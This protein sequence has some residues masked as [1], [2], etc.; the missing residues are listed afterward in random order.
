MT[1]NIAAQA[2]Q[3]AAQGQQQLQDY[4]NKAST[5]QSQF[6]DFNNQATA[7][8]QKVSNYTDYMQGEGSAANVYH[9]EQDKQLG[10]LGY[11]PEEMTAA[12]ANLNQATGALSAYSDFANT[13]A[14]KWG[15]NAGGFAAANAG[16]MQGINNNIAAN[17]GVVSSLSDLYKTA[18]TGAN[19]F[20]GNV[21][22]GQHE[23]LAGLKTVFDNAK[24]QADS[25]RSMMNFYDDLA[26]KQGGMNAQQQQ[27]YAQ[28][29]QAYAQATAAQAQASLY[30]QQAA[31]AK[32]QYT[33][34]EDLFSN[35]AAQRAAAVIK[36]AVPSFSIGPS[37]QGGTPIKI[38]G[39]TPTPPK[40]PSMVFQGSSSGIQGGNFRLQ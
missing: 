32:Q 23:T 11:K 1:V 39:N 16:A 21:V 8:N 30:A 12:R 22:A 24:S 25:A 15:M 10:E 2:A 34:Q 31:L 38:Q 14:S 7:A 27:F 13:S 3:A 29:Q 5:S 35:E 4:K 17:Q 37:L 28:A 40:T 9:G 19:Q 6:N 26:Q 20:T 36:S 18:Q 33:H